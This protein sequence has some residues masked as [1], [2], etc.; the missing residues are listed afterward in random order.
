MQKKGFYS[1]F[2]SSAVFMLL[3][4]ACNVTKFVPEDKY[5]LNKVKVNV[6]DN[7][8]VDPS[9]LRT[10]LRQKPNTE[11]L[12]FWKLQL[13]IY[14]TAPSDTTKKC[15]KVLARNAHRV[16]EAP[17]IYNEDLTSASMY[18]LTKAMQNKGY[19]DAVVDTAKQIKKRKLNLTYNIATGKPYNLR[20]VNYN[21]TNPYLLGI[22]HNE[23]RTKMKTG[24]LF[25]ADVLNE[26]RKRIET[27]MR[28]HGYFYFEKEML[29]FEAD[30]TQENHKVDVVMNVQPPLNDSTDS[31]Y[32]HVFRTYTVSRVCF[33]TDFDPNYAPDSLQVTTVQQGKYSFTYYGKQLLRNRVLMHNTRIRPGDIF[34]QRRVNRTYEIFNALGVI[35]YVDIS[36][37]QVAD[38]SLECHIVLSRQKLHSVAAQVEGTYTS[39][40]WGIAAEVGYTNRNIFRGAEEL[41]IKMR[42]GYEWRQGGGRAIEALVNAGLRFP[43]KLK[44]E[45]EGRYQDRPGEFNR[46]IGNAALSYAIHRYSN[47]RWSHNIRF[48]DISYVYLPYIDADF[49][50]K[51]FKSTN[52]LKYSYEDHFIAAFGYQVNYT[53]FNARMPYRSYG[54]FSISVETAGNALQ[55]LAKVAKFTTD[56]EGKYK[57][58]N[59]L[60]SQYAKF[61][62]MFTGHHIIDEN[63]R[64]V[65][66]GA[67]GLVMPYG[68]SDAVPFE[69]RYFAGG[70]N[71]VRGWTAR[72]LG[73]GSYVGDDYHIDYDNQ[74]GDIR[75]DLSAEYRLR[76]W[77]F[78]HAAAFVDAGNIWTI[79][80][81]ASQPGG[82][83][84]WN[85][86]YKQLGVSY[87]V[88]L[89]FDLSFLI[90][91]LDM[92]VRL[93]DP[94]LLDA[95]KQ[96]R[97]VGNGLSWNR[98]CA[99][100]FAIGYPF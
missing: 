77:K 26:E 7:K 4:S 40:D 14:N 94:E 55:A 92:G 53:S 47:A 70:A 6:E 18:H 27:E 99:L 80:G 98:D 28:A 43:N 86:F 30:S 96:W 52:L 68:N 95:G 16:G 58:G 51:F 5:L 64:F 9:E 3:L 85:T 54:T 35:K 34:D 19:F 49:K 97:T 84:H 91:R 65:F 72:A 31:L 11:I 38:D 87:G 20:T 15:N 23:R 75:L 63:N 29:R 12:G 21:I 88:G 36:F 37:H 60:F 74:A 50:Q 45:L 33:Y 71:S 13:H 10:Y 73:P 22:A 1:T 39:G 76:L 32:R 100:H 44:L 25:D 2:I 42:G 56:D 93:H 17:E 89:R 41:S 48:A 67:V 81:Y 59:I 79:H 66:R 8:D 69:K 61:D 24:M 90:L 83:F 57:L 62:F 82:T 46:V 78:I